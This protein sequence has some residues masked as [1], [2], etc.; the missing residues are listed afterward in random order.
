MFYKALLKIVQNLR[1]NIYT[2]VS[3]LTKLQDGVLQVYE[4]ETP[5]QVFSCEI[6][7]IFRNTYFVET[8]RV[9]ASEC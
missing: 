3:F 2:R 9:V 1:E 7:A 5:A 4:K 8:L 6:R